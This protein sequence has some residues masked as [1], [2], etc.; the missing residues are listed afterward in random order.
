MSLGVGGH[1]FGALIKRIANTPMIA[2][3]TAYDEE[4][5]I[6]HDD[7][8][9]YPDVALLWEHIGCQQNNHKT[10]RVLV[11]TDTG[12]E[13]DVQFSPWSPSR[14]FAPSRRFRELLTS[15]GARFP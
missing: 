7:T 9:Q 6:S 1:G 3:L 5:N 8:R 11:Q 15:W 14:S 13:C 12:F 4:G 2:T 10:V